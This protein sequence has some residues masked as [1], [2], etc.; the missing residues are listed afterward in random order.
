MNIDFNCNSLQSATLHGKKLLFVHIRNHS[1]PQTPRGALQEQQSTA[2]HLSYSCSLTT[3]QVDMPKE[4]G[5]NTIL[6]SIPWGMYR[7]ADWKGQQC[8]SFLWDVLGF[9]TSLIPCWMS[10]VSWSRLREGVEPR[11]VV[12]SL[13]SWT[14]CD[15]LSLQ[16]YSRKKRRAVS[17]PDSY[18]T[19]CTIIPETCHRKI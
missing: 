8:G 13:T 6:E 2:P 15:S 11:S 4:K 9:L 12:L 10:C 1:M 3:G 17:K 5:R 16:S 7:S 14:G 18:V 19:L